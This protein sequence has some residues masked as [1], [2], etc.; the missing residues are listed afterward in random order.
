MQFSNTTTKDGIIQL[1][2]FYTRLGDGGISGN[3]TFLKQFTGLINNAMNK[4][5]G[6]ILETNG[7]WDWDDTNYTDFPI[8]TADLVAGQLDYALPTA[9]GSDGAQSLLSLLR[10]EVQDNAGNWHRL[11]EVDEKQI[12]TGL[13]S[14]MSTNGLPEYYRLIG[15]SIELIPQA[16]AASVTLSGGLKCYFQRTQSRFVST[17]TTKQPG[18]NQLFHPMLALYAAKDWAGV[19]VLEQV[20]YLEGEISKA[21]EALKT[22]YANRRRD[23][24]PKI[25]ARRTNYN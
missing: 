5:I 17:D 25:R 24:K 20:S 23:E 6:K 21:E 3:A 1:T 13:G 19:N 16:A 14:F 4:V 22:Y 11:K 12:D 18:F 10:V 9:S 15:N 7:S 2:E 8:A